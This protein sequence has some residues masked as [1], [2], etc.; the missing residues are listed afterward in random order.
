M[1]LPGVYTPTNLTILILSLMSGVWSKYFTNLFSA[2]QELTRLFENKKED[3]WNVA[4]KQ[5]EH[6]QSEHKQKPKEESESNE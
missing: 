6:Y 5:Q 1:D 4:K 3:I 2:E